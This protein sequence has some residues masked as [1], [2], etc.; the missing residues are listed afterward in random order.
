MPFFGDLGKL[1]AGA[2]SDGP[3]NWA[4]ARQIGALIAAEGTSE[5]NV[6]P[7][8]RIR[9]E[10]LARVAELHVADATGLSTSAGGRSVTVRPTTRAEWANAALDAYKPLFEKLAASLAQTPPGA[11]GLSLADIADMEPDPDDV[12][13]DIDPDDPLAMLRGLVP[14][15][16]LGNL[17]SVMGPSLAGMQLGLMVGHLARRSL[18]P[19][20]LPIPRP[21]EDELVVV[22]ANV[23]GFASDWSLPPDDV[24]LWVCIDAIA[25]HAVLSRGHVRDRLLSLLLEHA[26]GFEPDSEAIAERLSGLDP[27]DQSSW[28]ALVGDP[29]TFV[30]SLQSDAQRRLIPQ[31]EAITVAIEGYV[32]YVMDKVGGKLIA[33]YGS[34]TEALRRRRVESNKGDRFVERLFGLSLGQA[35]YE[36]GQSF[37]RGIVERAGDDGLTR[38]WADPDTIPTPAEV[39]APGLWLARINLP[40]SPDQP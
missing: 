16:L 11:E 25:H 27:S 20:D 36:R 2:E 5:P 28:E 34:L 23:T 9:L 14:E 39:D 8:E 7:V 19:Y 24:R 30:G 13:S 29:D 18:G 4:V 31:I 37:V 10:E 35:Q 32:D 21:P 38:L 26:G 33:S 1:F 22:A 3:V 12:D 17:L 6:D 15:G 40:R